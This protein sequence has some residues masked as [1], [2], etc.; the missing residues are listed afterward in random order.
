MSDLPVLMWKSE[1]YS[2]DRE[3]ENIVSE[4]D[5]TLNKKIV[6]LED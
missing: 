6:A 4:Q 1:T 5:R 3:S 2:S